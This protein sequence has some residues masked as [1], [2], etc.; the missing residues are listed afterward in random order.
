M[1]QRKKR[2]LTVILLFVVCI[3][4]STILSYRNI[5]GIL[6][7]SYENDN[8]IV[9]SV[10]CNGIEN[11]FLRP[12]MVAETMSKDSILKEIVKHDTQKEA[13]ETEE[14]ASEYLESIRDG[15]GYSIV[16]AVS[17]LSKA[18]FISN[19]ILKFLNYGEDYHYEC[20]KLFL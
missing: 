14:Y 11:S 8:R 19:G 16:F 3:G 2:F 15:F 6:D 9:A 7:D 18:Y 20:Y 10:I 13:I 17:D 1:K 4:T 12:I 5:K